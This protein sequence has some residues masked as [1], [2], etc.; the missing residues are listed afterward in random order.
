MVGSLL[1]GVLIAQLIY[2]R[3]RGSP[4]DGDMDGDWVEP[5]GSSSNGQ[6]A[7]R[8][9][10]LPEALAGDDGREGLL[11]DP[12][13]SLT[14]SLCEPHLVRGAVITNSS[15]KGHLR[16][17]ARHALLP[18]GWKTAHNQLRRGSNYHFI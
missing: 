1:L 13:S 14:W 9:T 2:Q 15:A 10:F 12:L 16:R 7:G 4:E 18:S 11:S 5:T 8:R 17:G 6:T 3:Q